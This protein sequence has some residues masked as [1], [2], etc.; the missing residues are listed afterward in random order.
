MPY[1][2]TTLRHPVEKLLEAEHFLARMIN[3]DGLEFQFELNAFLSASRSVTFVL[4]QAFFDVPDFAVWY[5]T[6]QARMRADDAMRFFLEL[7][8]VSQ[9]QGPVSIVGGS[10]PQG[11]WTYR[12]IGRPHAVPIELIGH[13]VCECCAAHLT[14]LATLLSE[15]A[16][17]FPFHSCPRSAFTEEGMVELGYSLRDVEAVLGLPDGYTALGDISTADKLRILRREIEPLDENSIRRIAARDLRGNG[18]PLEFP[19]TVDT[20]L[21]DDIATM[22]NPSDA[23]A[24]QPRNLFLAGIMKRI[25]DIESP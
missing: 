17:T 15:C 12:F 11:G 23:N 5:K 18:F 13:D 7:R 20:D 2:F 22:M 3:S 21:V 25:S 14:K 24:G 10:L 4:Q 9:K 1:T 8:N 19:D 6:Q 16:R